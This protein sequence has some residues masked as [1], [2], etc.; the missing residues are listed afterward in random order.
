M[1]GADGPGPLSQNPLDVNLPRA[2]LVALIAITAVALILAASTSG[3]A[4]GAYN[5]AWDGAADLQSE[6]RTVGAESDLVLN[7]TAYGSVQANSTVAVVLSP[8]RPYTETETTR[9]RRFVNQGGTLVVAEDFGNHSNGLLAGVGATARF[10]GSL[11]R[12]ERYNYRSP[13]MLV[14]T[15]VSAHPMVDGVGKLTIN[16]GTV[17]EPHESRSVAN[18]SGYAYLDRNRNDG[19]DDNESLGTYPVV[20]TERVGEGRVIVV[21]DPSLFI[22]AML[23]RPGNRRFVHNVFGAHERVLLD[24][25]HAERLPPLALALEVVR[26]NPLLQVVVLGAGVVLVGAWGRGHFDALSDRVSG[27]SHVDDEGLSRS[28]EEIV[29]YLRH[30]HPEWDESRLERIAR[31]VGDESEE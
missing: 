24:Y 21:S 22:N 19:L 16:H 11:V 12:D 27:E 17:V 4:F 25:S 23:D 10:D 5:P 2:L 18:T 29:A 20:T 14:A 26:G 13:A 28:R 7:T 3:A 8:D 31:T 1:T 9:L 6:A 15:N 30:Q